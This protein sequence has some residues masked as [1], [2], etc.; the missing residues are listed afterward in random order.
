MQFLFVYRVYTGF[1]AV[2]RPISHPK[3]NNFLNYMSAKNCCLNFTNLNDKVEPYLSSGI[4][5]D[6]LL[7]KL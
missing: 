3:I 2:F 4:K 7:L 6:S 5:S 1:I